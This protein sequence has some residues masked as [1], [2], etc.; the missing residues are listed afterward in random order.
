MPLATA[1]TTND[2]KTPLNNIRGTLTVGIQ[3]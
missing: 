1:V 2:Q 3:R